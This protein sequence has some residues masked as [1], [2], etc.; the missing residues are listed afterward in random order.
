M[1]LGRRR[2]PTEVVGNV[3]VHVSVNGQRQEFTHEQ[4]LHDTTT[5]HSIAIH[6]SDRSDSLMT[7][8]F[9]SHIHIQP[10]STVIF[11]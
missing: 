6:S 9:S 11:N 10:S 7:S 4:H 1:C 3:A 8:S 5:M 2:T